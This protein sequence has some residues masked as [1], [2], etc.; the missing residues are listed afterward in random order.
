MAKY[1][2]LQE[3]SFK[4]AVFSLPMAKCVELQEMYFKTFSSPRSIKCFAHKVG[5][6]LNQISLRTHKGDMF[7]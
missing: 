7:S 4:T 6:T 1:V 2:E 5:G 3:I